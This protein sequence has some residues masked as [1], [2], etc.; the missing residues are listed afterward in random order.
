MLAA[1]PAALS[2]FL[3]VEHV[4]CS[5]PLHQMQKFISKGVCVEQVFSCKWCV[6][7]RVVFRENKEGAGGADRQVRWGLITLSPSSTGC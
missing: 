6:C 2:V 5:R 3:Q 1:G 7:R 4:C